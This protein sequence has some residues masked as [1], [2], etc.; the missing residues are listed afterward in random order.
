MGS[1]SEDGEKGILDNMKLTVIH[2]DIQE[3]VQAFVADACLSYKEIVPEVYGKLAK[4]LKDSLDSKF[5]PGWNVI[6]GENYTGSCSVAKNHF[7]EIS[8][9]NIRVLVFK[10]QR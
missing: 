6:V 5:K 1:K 9:C 8:I 10:S 2:K 4:G 7:L 3:D